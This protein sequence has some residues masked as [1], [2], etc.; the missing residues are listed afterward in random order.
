M[1]CS[2]QSQRHDLVECLHAGLHSAHC[3]RAH[4]RHMAQRQQTMHT[5]IFIYID[6]AFIIER[7]KH[8]HAFEY[9][10]DTKLSTLSFYRALQ[11]MYR[12]AD[13][14]SAIKCASNR[15]LVSRF[16]TGCRGLQVDTD[17]WANNVIT[18]RCCLVCKSLGCVEGEQRFI[19]DCPAYSYITA[20]HVPL[21]LFLHCCTVADF[22]PLC[23]P[24]ACGG[25]LRDCLAS[26]KEDF[27]C[28]N[29]LN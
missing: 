15:R 18:S 13:Y 27:A 2:T 22:M 28:M 4:G 9:F 19:F 12:Y 23:E 7:A 5:Y 14:L 10:T 21:N 26:R 8:Q 25:F 1:S 24:N 11:L 17:R 29:S 16:R 3:I 6:I 20:K